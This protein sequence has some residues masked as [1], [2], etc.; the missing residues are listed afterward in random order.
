MMHNYGNN[1]KSICLILCIQMSTELCISNGAYS[2]SELQC[3]FVCSD[4]I[5]S[6]SKYMSQS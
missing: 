6:H 4:V 3:L 1:T 2:Q 5:V